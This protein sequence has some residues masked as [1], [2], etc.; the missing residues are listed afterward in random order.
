M[1]GYA[2]EQEQIEAIKKWWKENGKFIIVGVILGLLVLF[3]T[4]TWV[5]RKNSI[6]E[7]ASIE[8]EQLLTELKQKNNQVVDERGKHIISS[9]PKTPY[10]ALAAM[11][12][13]K[14]KLEDGDNAAAR[15]QLQWAF[16]H[17]EQPEIKDTARLRLAKVLIAQGDP[18][19]VVTLL[20]GVNAEN[21][22]GLYEEVRGDAY[23]A[24]GD[25]A[26]AAQSYK[27][28]L[29]MLSPGASTQQLQMKLDDIAPGE[30]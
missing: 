5:A 1:E 20:E 17:A 7:A 19:Q 16:D 23:I 24:M 10:A 9:Y 11:A 27:K 22:N 21:F 13:A 6:A 3:G 25:T 15:A 12:I 29:T 18:A 28:A 2:S 4:K 8:F 26:K 30:N 14:T